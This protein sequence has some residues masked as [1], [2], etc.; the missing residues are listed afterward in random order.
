[1]LGV[2]DGMDDLTVGRRGVLLGEVLA[3]RLE[4]PCRERA[5]DRVRACLHDHAGRPRARH[6]Q[7]VDG[8]LL[9]PVILA[10][11]VRTPRDT[12]V[13]GDCDIVRA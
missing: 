7:P 4:N 11:L 10:G 1:M 8:I 3:E 12:P 6:A 13:D 5:G 2:P 9:N